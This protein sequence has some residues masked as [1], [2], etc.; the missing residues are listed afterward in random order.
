MTI[1]ASDPGARW[2]VEVE[3]LSKHFGSSTALR[4]VTMRIPQGC[5]AA[6]VGP[7]GAGKTTLLRMVAT[8]ARPSGGTIRVA[9]L[10]V[11]R[12][13]GRVRQSI[14]FVSHQTYLYGDLSAQDN[15]RFYGRLYGVEDLKQRVG[16]L[17]AQ[18]GLAERHNALVR[19]LS[20][21]MQQRLSIARSVLHQP[22]LVV[23]DEPYTG[24]D[25]CAADA[26]TCVLHTLHA[27][28]RT[29]LMTSHEWSHVAGLADRLIVLV[30]GRVAFE[31]PAKMLSAERL[32]EIY[33]RCVEGHA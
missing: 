5:C 6:I 30:A 2:A 7:N 3:H 13:G 23:L 27:D 17:L 11:G 31:T 21:G 1:S 19:T 9:G 15:L 12:W 16:T 14:G 24:L 8:L 33:S 28:G 20:R 18:F 32:R 10:D 4:D 26:L 29:L 22:R 25:Q